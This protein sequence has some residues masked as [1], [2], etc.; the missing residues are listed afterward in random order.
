MTVGELKEIIANLD[1]DLELVKMNDSFRFEELYIN[2]TEGVMME[3]NKI[4]IYGK[5]DG[6]KIAWVLYV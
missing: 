1:D 4:G 6:V 3:K 5:D 2:I